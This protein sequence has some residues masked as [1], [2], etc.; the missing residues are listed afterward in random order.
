MVLS[1]KRLFVL[2]VL[3]LLPCAAIAAEKAKGKV[4]P[5]LD[6]GIGTIGGELPAADG[7]ERKKAKQEGVA[8]KVT[9]SADAT[10]EVVEVQNAWD[11]TRSAS[12]M[13]PVGDLLT[14]ITLYGKPPTT[15]K[16]TT[17]VRIKA[18]QPVTAP[19]ELALLDPRGDTAMS[20]SGELNFKGAKDGE[21][22]WL[23]DWAPVARPTGG[24]FKLLIR[25]AGRPMGTWPLKVVEEKR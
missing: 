13:K 19:I 23:I 3:A 22:S 18:T 20:G 6:L 4:K 17:L 15:Q 1:G 7:I 9:T 11:F 5:K 25:V 10:F 21:V 14:A 12:G 8:P 16:F 24:D 2:I